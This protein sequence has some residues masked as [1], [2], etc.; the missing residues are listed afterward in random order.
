[1]PDVDTL[2]PLTQ[3][4]PCIRPPQKIVV[5]PSAKNIDG[6]DSEEFSSTFNT[7]AFSVTKGVHLLVV[8][9]FTPAKR[10]CF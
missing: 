9:Y 8:F 7:T 10:H 1:M 4:A 2:D 3:H 5:L 6:Y